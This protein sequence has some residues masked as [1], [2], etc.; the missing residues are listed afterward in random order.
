VFA[1]L[2]SDH[3]E[4]AEERLE[5]TMHQID[6]PVPLTIPEPWMREWL[7]RGHE[8]LRDYLAKYDAYRAYCVMNELE[9]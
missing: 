2:R 9:P 6:R 8:Q 1:A 4:A 7:D 3:L 5:D